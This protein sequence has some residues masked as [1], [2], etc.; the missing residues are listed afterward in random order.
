MA[1]DRNLLYVAPN[2]QAVARALVSW[3]P[4][5]DSALHVDARYLGHVDRQREWV[6]SM[7]CELSGA[8][9]RIDLLVV[10]HV[11][12]A[13]KEDWN[14]LSYILSARA[15]SGL[16]TLVDSAEPF[17]DVGYS[18]AILLDAKEAV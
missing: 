7:E 15:R 10:T 16:I 13:S 18:E 8:L 11:L 4:R 12:E 5:V 2:D 17:D 3:G 1:L 14:Y 6:P 9:R